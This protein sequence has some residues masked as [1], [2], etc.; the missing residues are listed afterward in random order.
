MN[1]MKIFVSACLLGRNTKYDGTNNYNK[2]LL[3][4]LKEHELFTLCPEV[5][6]GLGIPRDPCEQ[7]GNKVISD[8]GKDCTENYLLGAK[9]VLDICLKNDIHVAVLK[10]RSPSCGVASVY[11]GS[12][13]H[14]LIASSGVTTLLLKENGIKVFSEEEL[15]DLKKYLILR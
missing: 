10:E 5:A 11:D 14:Q 15:D 1:S 12:F 9:K 8:K 6:G 2:E 13:N 4:I 7:I 3:E